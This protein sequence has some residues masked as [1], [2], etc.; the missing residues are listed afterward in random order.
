[1]LYR[2]FLLR[3]IDLESLS[4]DGDTTRLLGQFAALLAGI[5][6]L[7]TIPL[8][9]LGGRLSQSLLWMMEHL[10]IAT[11]MAV[12][13]LFSV[14]SWDALVSDRRDVL[15]L[16]P[17]PIHTR[18]LFYAKFAALAA[19]L[20]LVLVSLNVF[21]GLIWPLLFSPP[22]RG[23]L[24][25]VRS[26]AAYWTTIV[27]AAAFTFCAV[28]GVQGIAAQ[29]LSRQ[30]YLRLSAWL[31][32][33]GFCL[34]V[35]LYFLEP[36]LETREAL[37]AP[38]NQRLLAYLPSYWFLGLFQQ[39]NGSLSPEFSSLANRAWVCLTL[40]GC[41]ARAT[42]LVSYFRTLRKLVEEPDILPAHRPLTW[43]THTGNAADSGLIAI[44]SFSVRTLLRSRQHRLIA[45]FI[46]GAGG[47]T[48]LAYL[49]IAFGD[50]GVLQGMRMVQTRVSVLSASILLLCVAVAG[51]R[52]VFSIPVSLRANW[53]FRM[54]ELLEVSAYVASVRRTLLAMSVVPIWLAIAIVLTR[55]WPLG[56]A[57]EHLLALAMFGGCL[58]ELSL[59]GFQKVPFTCSYLPGKTNVHVVFWASVLLAIP[60]AYE[61]AKLEQR[62]LYSRSGYILLVLLLGVG[63]ASAQRCAKS[64]A[65]A[66]AHLK[67]EEASDPE[68]FGLKLDRD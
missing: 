19:S 41:A 40:A 25:C 16:A 29:L 3:V 66:A 17:L 21:T 39:L 10:L 47:A 35:G 2:V 9:T 49:R 22:G 28:L 1:V 14:L 62:L 26:L 61:V 6:F 52:L 46:L 54:T 7:F 44:L 8:I 57:A 58:V 60:L 31:Q 34:F 4:A 5:S 12:V 67:F 11:T 18:T 50:R 23:V 53:I 68:I 43:W 42:L 51:I 20:G 38:E 56:L 37:T 59:L 45:S 15:V 24:G 27:L 30:R 64:Q 55:F 65:T 33:M 32:V 36:S 63:W 13:G 48:V